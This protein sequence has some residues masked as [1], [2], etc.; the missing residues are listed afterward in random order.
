[1]PFVL[2]CKLLNANQAR[3]FINEYT[4]IGPYGKEEIV[5]PDIIKL[6]GENFSVIGNEWFERMYNAFGRAK[7]PEVID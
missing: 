4:Y 5:W 6:P 7:V 1:L 3:L 2:R